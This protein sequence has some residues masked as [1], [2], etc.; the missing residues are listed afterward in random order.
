MKTFIE[1]LLRKNQVAISESMAKK[2]F[3]DEDP[4]EKIL[5]FDNDQDFMVSGVYKDIPA[6][7][8]FQ[9]DM[10][11]SF[12]TREEEYSRQ[13]WLDQNY[14]TYL[15]LH[16]DA[17]VEDVEALMNEIA[18]EKMSVELK[19]FLDMTFEQFEASGNSFK[20]MLQPL[21]GME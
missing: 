14:Q 15:T 21:D 2:Y 17:N 1:S 7:S 12:I 18:V 19:Q 20:Y 8:H 5:R 10:L 11:M 6:N 13:Q 16:P 3:G 9:F 4:M